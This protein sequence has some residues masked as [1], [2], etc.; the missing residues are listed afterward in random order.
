MQPMPQQKLSKKA[1]MR[2]NPSSADFEAWGNPFSINDVESKSF[3]LG[4][5]LS[6]GR[7]RTVFELILTSLIILKRKLGRTRAE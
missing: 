6:S 7:F 3:R 5:G 2:D 4:Y 1:M